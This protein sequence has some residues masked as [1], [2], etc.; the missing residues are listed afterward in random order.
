[1]TSELPSLKLSSTALSTHRIAFFVFN[2]QQKIH[3]LKLAYEKMGLTEVHIS[4]VFFRFEAIIAQ[5]KIE[6]SVVRKLSDLNISKNDKTL[7]LS[8]KSRKSRQTSLL[9][10]VIIYED[11][12]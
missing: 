12:R 11:Y 8:S 6:S 10:N 4:I 3:F 2:E 9:E 7:Y 5:L 1:M